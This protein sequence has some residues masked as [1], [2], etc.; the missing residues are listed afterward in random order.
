V[1]DS[2][3]DRYI[4]A[5]N[6]SIYPVHEKKFGKYVLAKKLISV[7]IAKK[8]LRLFVVMLSHCKLPTTT[9]GM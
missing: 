8:V 3:V 9:V 7:L 1:L 5:V 6:V 2:T 4:T